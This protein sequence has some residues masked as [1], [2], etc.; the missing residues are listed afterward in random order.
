M[1]LFVSFQFQ[2]GSIK[3]HALQVHRAQQ[4]GS[5]NSKLVRLKVCRKCDM[6]LLKAFQFQTGSI[7]S[8]GI[9]LLQ[10]QIVPFQFQTGSIKSLHLLS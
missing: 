9:I 6:G 10:Y 2:T 7:K 5:F 3:S 4:V 1:Q 8:Y